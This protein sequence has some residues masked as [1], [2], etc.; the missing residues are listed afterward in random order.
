MPKTGSFRDTIAER[1]RH[2]PAFLDAILDG[3]KEAFHDG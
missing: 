3:V 1:A 2:D